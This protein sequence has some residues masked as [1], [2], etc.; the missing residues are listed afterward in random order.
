M[1]VCL[2]GTRI[3]INPAVEV[4][5]SIMDLLIKTRKVLADGF[6]HDDLPAGGGQQHRSLARQRG[7]KRTR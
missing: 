3:F 5:R 7:D 1:R 4:S 2:R 6:E